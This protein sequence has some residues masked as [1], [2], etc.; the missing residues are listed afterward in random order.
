MKQELS[1]SKFPSIEKKMIDANFR[2]SGFDYMRLIL[3]AGVILQ[4]AGTTSYGHEFGEILPYGLDRA[5]TPY[6]VAMFFTL[7]GF[8]V[9]G[10]LFRCK[11]LVSFLG[12]RVTRIMPALACEVLLSAIIIGPMLTS[13]DLHSYFSDEKF[14]IYFLNIIGDIHYQLPGLFSTNPLQNTVNDQ[15]WTI[16]FELICYT[17]ISALAFVGIATR[18]YLLL[19]FCVSIQIALAVFAVMHQSTYSKLHILGGISGYHDVYF[20]VIGILFYSFRDKIPYSFGVFVAAFVLSEVLLFV[21]G[22]NNFFGFPVAYITVYLGLT[23]PAK[24]KVLFSGDYSYGM[25]LYGFPIQQAIAYFMPNHRSW[26]SNFSLALIGAFLFAHFSWWCVEKP[27]LS[28]KSKL[29]SLEG[30]VLGVYLS[31]ARAICSALR[32]GSAKT[33]VAPMLKGRL[34]R[35]HPTRFETLDGLRGTAALVVVLF[36]VTLNFKIPLMND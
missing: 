13:L 35:M 1:M 14:K 25:Y 23:N 4:H 30:R 34:S 10:S 20:F 6:L 12:L 28:V 5:W 9:S 31:E 19:V 11:S 33:L 32:R 22:G 27:A 18:R 24:P 36:H 16:P 7:S 17:V 2:S 29:L 26:V 21:P 3:C 15:L 8:L